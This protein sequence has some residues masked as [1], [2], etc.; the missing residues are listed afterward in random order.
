MLKCSFR[1]PHWDAILS[2]V[3]LKQ[4]NACCSRTVVEL[5]CIELHDK[6]KVLLGRNGGKCNRNAI[7]GFDTNLVCCY[8]A[9]NLCGRFLACWTIHSPAE[10]CKWYLNFINMLTFLTNTS[11]PS[12]QYY[13]D[14]PNAAQYF[15]FPRCYPA[16]YKNVTKRQTNTNEVTD[17]QKGGTK[18]YHKSPFTYWIQ[19]PIY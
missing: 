5:F 8:R 4:R 18:T 19:L 6:S 15:C 11:V 14:I 1:W 16:S 17:C 10:Y 7:L 3:T 12:L 2:A 9:D 13:H